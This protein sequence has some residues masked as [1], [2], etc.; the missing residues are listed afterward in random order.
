MSSDLGPLPKIHER[1]EIVEN[2]KQHL[3]MKL[4]EWSRDASAKALTS[5]EFVK[6]VTAVFSSELLGFAKHLIRKER[7]GDTDKPGGLE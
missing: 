3:S 6:V 2:A 1:E 5:A 7:H 4:A